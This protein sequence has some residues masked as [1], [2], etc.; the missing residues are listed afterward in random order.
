M[1]DSPRAQECANGNKEG[2]AGEQPQKGQ[3]NSTLSNGL[4]QCQPPDTIPAFYG[5]P[6]AMTHKPK[7]VLI[8]DDDEGMRDTLTAILRRDYTVLTASTVLAAA[9]RKWT[10]WG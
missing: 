3:Q 4:Q 9:H 5:G 8:V 10:L 7:T 2:C 6:L 1:I